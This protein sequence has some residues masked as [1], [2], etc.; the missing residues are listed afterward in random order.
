MSEVPWQGDVLQVHPKVSRLPE[1]EDVCFFNFETR[2]IGNSKG[3]WR[4]FFGGM[5]SGFATWRKVW[6]A[7]L[8]LWVG[9]F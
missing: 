4:I 2:R 9:G 7:S 3:A 5:V 8:P 6:M 1:K